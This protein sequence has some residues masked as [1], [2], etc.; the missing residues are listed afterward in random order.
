MN[1]MLSHLIKDAEETEGHRHGTHVS[2]EKLD[3]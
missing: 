1:I 3:P 2:F